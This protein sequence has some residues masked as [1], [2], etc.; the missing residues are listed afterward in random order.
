M[1]ITDYKSFK[2]LGEGVQAQVFRAKHAETHQV[3]AIKVL[4]DYPSFERERSILGKIAELQLKNSI[5]LLDSF[6]IGSLYYLVIDYVNSDELHKYVLDR[7][8]VQT[9]E[10]QLK[11]VFVKILLAVRELHQSN[12]CHLDLKLEN[13]LYHHKAGE[14][15]LID[16]GFAEPTVEEKPDG[17]VADRLL[18]KF[19][20]SIH[21][22]APEIINNQPYDGKKVDVWALGVLLYVLAAREFPFPGESHGHDEINPTTVYRQILRGHVHWPHYFSANL[23]DLIDI[24]LQHSPSK[25]PSIDALLQHPWLKFTK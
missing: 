3:V 22:S 11:A 7:L 12:I 10:S 16:F 15:K 2:L 5:K 17:K 21:Y 23:V 6:I 1:T 9:P 4:D 19:C 13:I 24:M 8:Y 25:R 14:V 20:G 18:E